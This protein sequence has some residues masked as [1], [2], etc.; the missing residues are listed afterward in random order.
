MKKARLLFPTLLM[1]LS[2]PHL[3][4]VNTGSLAAQASKSI[5]SQLPP[6][7]PQQLRTVVI[8]PGHGGHDPGCSGAHSRE[9]HLTLAVGRY[10]AEALRQNYPELKIIMTRDRD[11]FLPLH[12]RAEIATRNKADLFIS[13]HCNYIVG[14]RHIHGTET[15]VMGLHVSEE[16]LEVAKRE[17]AAILYE[18]NYQ[19]TYGYDPNSPEAHIIF[20]MF[21]NAF[22]EQSISF[23]SKVQKY[24]ALEASRRDRGVKQAGFLVL[25]HATM[26]SVLVETGYL[27]NASDEEFLRSE[28]GQM[29]MANA[30]LMAFHEYKAE[31]E[32]VPLAQLRPPVKLGEGRLANALASSQPVAIAERP[33]PIN[34]G[35]GPR[36]VPLD[37]ERRPITAAKPTPDLPQADSTD[38]TSPSAPPARPEPASKKPDKQ[39]EAHAVAPSASQGSAETSRALE[40]VEQVPARPIFCVQLA[41]SPKPLDVSRGKWQ[42]IGHTVEVIMEDGLYKYQIRNFSSLED[43][44][45]MRKQLRSIGFD[46][47]FIVAYLGQRKVNPYTLSPLK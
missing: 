20:S 45:G 39:E 15:Y 9:K 22:L 4:D 21:Q 41:A 40:P 1:L 19:E 11:V 25:R 30:L 13:I 38:E 37:S 43:A 47:A 18:E 42:Q 46:D 2:T 26:P 14:K 7:A 5:E 44:Q 29:A 28:A 17:N 35:N 3:P 6:K 8:D 10:F 31:Y 33:T 34:T 32:G 16:N 23:A 36:S 24:A 12:E 27:S